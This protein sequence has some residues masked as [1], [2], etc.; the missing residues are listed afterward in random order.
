MSTREVG[1]VISDNILSAKRI[2]EESKR[3]KN[4]FNSIL[5]QRK[6]GAELLANTREARIR[7]I[8]LLLRANRENYEHSVNAYLDSGSYEAE[9]RSELESLLTREGCSNLE[10]ETNSKSS[11]FVVEDL[12]IFKPIEQ[13]GQAGS[14][15]IPGFWVAPGSENSATS[16]RE[17][18]SAPATD[19]TAASSTDADITRVWDEKAKEWKNYVLS[20]GTGDINRF[21]QSDPVLW[22]LLGN[23][24]GKTVLDLGCGNGYLSRQLARKRAN[25]IGVDLSSQ[26]IEIAKNQTPPELLSRIDY[27]VESGSNL[28]SI[29]NQTVDQVVANYVLMDC[30]NLK[31]T[32]AS[33]SRVLKSD[34]T[35]VIVMVHPCFPIKYRT[36]KDGRLII[37]WEQ[38]YLVPHE[39]VTP[40]FS[41]K[42]STPFHIFHRSLENYTNSFA[43][44]GFTIE[45]LRE[46]HLTDKQKKY[47]DPKIVKILEDK[48]ISIV[49]QLRKRDPYPEDFHARLMDGS[50]ELF[51]DCSE[52][53][54]VRESEKIWLML[55]QRSNQFSMG[56]FLSLHIERAGLMG[57]LTHETAPKLKQAGK[58]IVALTCT[59]GDA[60]REQYNDLQPELSTDIKLISALIETRT[61]EQIS[62]TVFCV[63]DKKDIILSIYFSKS[64]AEIMSHLFDF[65]EQFLPGLRSEDKERSLLLFE[66]ILEKMEGFC[67]IEDVS[68]ELREVGREFCESLNNLSS[69]EEFKSGLGQSVRMLI[70]AIGKLPDSS[71]SKE[72][73]FDGVLTRT[74]DQ[75]SEIDPRFVPIIQQLN[76][77][78][79]PLII[80]AFNTIFRQVGAR[81]DPS[82]N[83]LQKIRAKIQSM[84]SSSSATIDVKKLCSRFMEDSDVKLFCAAF[85]R[86]APLCC[87][88]IELAFP[89][90][91]P[92]ID[93]VKK[94]AGGLLQIFRNWLENNSAPTRAAPSVE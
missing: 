89:Q 49:F 72:I 52:E 3:R 1:K 77:Q 13:L 58:K 34:G 6:S 93:N 66:K 90:T 16:A 31:A 7:E 14:W 54:R 78:I 64:S 74:L 15:K 65:S 5:N 75:F 63:C 81:I 53:L 27:R 68:G 41:E 43:D 55:E 82:Q 70:S 32:V 56:C 35:A 62:R 33:I 46:P 87:N 60:I 9:L 20:D 38:P 39:Q 71:D 47:L 40:P 50:I 45:A 23:V 69:D 57:L 91:K 94:I 24:A 4:V 30:A 17:D 86:E 83:C 12:S 26:M 79:S 44:A 18:A 42:F 76:E 88:E 29:F 36:E 84:Q 73:Y 2:E 28:T 61:R 21:Y 37:D 48:P 10:V 19:T 8:R 22:E 85:T 80:D 25:V 67:R 92:A 59:I 11:S 51:R